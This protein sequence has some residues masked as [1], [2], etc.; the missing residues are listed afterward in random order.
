MI[1]RGDVVCAGL[2]GGADSV[3]LFLILLD[4]RSGL[5][6]TLEA[7]HLNHNLRGADSLHDEAFVKKLCAEHG[8]KLR[9]FSRDVASEAKRLNAGLEQAG[10]I[11]RKEIGE[12][13]LSDGCTKIALAHNRND[14]AE[15]F[16]FNIS[17]GCSITGL[18]GIRPVSGKIIRP[19][20]PFSK[21][22]IEEEL[23][24]RG[25]SWCTD[26]TNYD[27]SY[28]RNYI[29]GTVI[30]ALEKGVNGRITEHILDLSADLILAE[31]IIEDRV[32]SCYA[33]TV[34]ETVNGCIIDHS[35][36]RENP[37]VA[38]M[39]IKRCL[40]NVSGQKHDISRINIR[41]V[42]DLFRGQK[43]RKTDLPYQMCAAGDYSGVIV[44]RKP[45]IP[46]APEEVPF[47]PETEI[48]AAGAVIVSETAEY[49]GKIKDFK[50]EKNQYTKCFDYD[51][52]NRNCVLRTRKPGDRI[53]IGPGGRSKKL[54]E[55]FTDRKISTSDRDRI[56]LLAEGSIV[57]WVI[58]FRMGDS[59][60]ITETTERVLRITVSGDYTDEFKD[61]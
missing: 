20:L 38:D 49:T 45:D 13:C 35:L 51:K 54:K 27:Q 32:D 40:E 5:D 31:E 60:K 6:F 14:L 52:I 22:E 1:S 23:L 16:L 10:H 11:L 26:T 56:L 44:F 21:K 59:A 39:V 58:G 41:D 30:P 3:C 24:K 37:L 15:T 53:I 57:H 42:E 17:R 29:R 33:E 28:T 19:L 4:L 18:A 12:Q 50:E 34:K 7:F 55:F 9:L 47:I 36:I 48:K 43:G 25:A 2:S 46:S 8:V 61:R